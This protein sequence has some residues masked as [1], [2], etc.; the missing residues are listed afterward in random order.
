MGKILLLNTGP[1]GLLAKSAEA[2]AGRIAEYNVSMVYTCPVPG[3]GETARIIAGSAPVECLPGFTGK[4]AGFW[5][6]LEAGEGSSPD[7]P[8]SGVPRRAELD[9]PFNEG[10]EGLRSRLE[11]AFTQI[12][13]KHRKETV[14]VVSQRALTVIMILHLLHMNNSHYLQ[15]AQENGAVNLFETRGGI[16]SA[17]YINDTCHLHGLI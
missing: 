13:E 7:C 15:I 10:I 16:P 3:A 17:L 8:V 9:L 14:A 4:V 1:A 11:T 2:A 5:K 12:A 6:D